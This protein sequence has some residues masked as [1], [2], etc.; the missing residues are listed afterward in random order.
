MITS[1]EDASRCGCRSRELTVGTLRLQ[2]V[3]SLAFL[4]SLQESGSHM[5]NR[6]VSPGGR[7]TSGL[8]PE[9]DQGQVPAPE[10]VLGLEQVLAVH[11]FCPS[12][13]QNACHFI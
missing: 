9:G 13:F 3:G 12:S 7:P 2:E 4:R 11:L 10:M 5:G 8:M 1:S 6:G